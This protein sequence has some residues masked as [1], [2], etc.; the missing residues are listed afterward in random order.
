MLQENFLKA[1]LLGFQTGNSNILNQGDKTKI[2][3][4]VSLFYSNCLVKMKN[5]HILKVLGD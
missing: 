3:N 5:K 4:Y 1:K 2:L